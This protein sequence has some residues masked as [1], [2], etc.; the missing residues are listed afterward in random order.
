MIAAATILV[1][2]F[3]ED[4]PLG[5]QQEA[6]VGKVLARICDSA[7]RDEAMIYA[8][9]AT[10]QVPDAPLVID[11]AGKF[12]ASQLSATEIEQFL[13]MVDEIAGR[14]ETPPQFYSQRVRRLRQKLGLQID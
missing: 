5:P 2:I 13:A 14:C 10:K 9:W 1:A 12:L 6:E 7:M 11:R 3:A 4:G 8:K